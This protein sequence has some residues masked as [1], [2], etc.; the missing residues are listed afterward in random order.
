MILN[1]LPWMMVK[2]LLC[3]IVI[4]V[5]FGLIFRIRDKKDILNIVLVNVLTNPIVVSIPVFVMF[6]YGMQARY[7][8]LIILELL[9]VL[10]EGFIYYKVLKYKKIN[11]FV[12][13]LLLN[14]ASYLIGEV[15]NKFWI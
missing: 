7:I 4:E 12:L 10:V 11:P 3:T 9:T 15:I 6:R 8:V 5:I 13:S 2:C 1:D 14:I